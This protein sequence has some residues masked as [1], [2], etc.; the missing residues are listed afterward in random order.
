MATVV[1]YNGVELHNVHTKQWDEEVIYDAS[2]TDLMF[3]RVKMRFSGI[4]HSEYNDS[5]NSVSDAPAWIALQNGAGPG[6]VQRADA[7]AMFDVI[8]A[9]L[10]Q[11]RANLTVKMD[12]RGENVQAIISVAAYGGTSNVCDVDNG[13]KPVSCTLAAI[14][15][16]KV[17][18]LEFAIEC[19]YPESPAAGLALGSVINNRWSVAEAMD[20]NFFTTRTIHGR[21]RLTQPYQN[22]QGARVVVVPA[23]EPGFRRERF[24]FTVSETNL[25]CEY[26]IVDRQIYV[27]APWPATKLEVDYTESTTEGVMFSGEVCIHLDG[28]P[29]ADPALMLWQALRVV[30]SRLDIATKSIGNGYMLEGASFGQHF[31]ERNAVDVRVRIRHVPTDKENDTTWIAD[32]FAKKFTAGLDISKTI[33]P[34]GEGFFAGTYNWQVSTTPPYFGYEPGGKNT[35][36]NPYAGGHAAVLFALSCYNQT[37]WSDH[38]IFGGEMFQGQPEKVADTPQQPP[39]GTAVSAPLPSSPGDK[40]SD[41]TREAMYT[42]ARME[43]RIIK[44]FLRAQ[45]P[46]S[47]DWNADGT[48]DENDTCAVVSLAAPVA[49]RELR[50]DF[51]RVGTWPEIPEDMDSYSEPLGAMRG[52][53]LASWEKALPPVLAADR[54]KQVYRIEAYR[55]WALTRPPQKLLKDAVYTGV[56]PQTNVG[57]LD[58]VMS[59]SEDLYSD[60]MK[61]GDP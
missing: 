16:N 29:A 22:S 12:N 18:R 54:T 33:A 14:V 17:F 46:I 9:K 24:D 20:D 8:R 2:H 45:L 21:M 1:I 31:G 6:G 34:P 49:Q 10:L 44:S 25:E 61:P 60:R 36:R 32:M 42:Y 7:A 28:G 53:L 19:C 56:Q 47:R 59:Y 41:E 39:I 15:G 58:N 35:G 30:D 40:L 23:L 48:G 57:P 43:S 51:E 50:C 26:S 55:L 11:P 27:A 13:P 5:G 3:H 38:R 37:P 4:V 52:T